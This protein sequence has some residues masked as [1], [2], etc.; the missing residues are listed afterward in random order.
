LLLGCSFHSKWAL[1]SIAKEAVNIISNKAFQVRTNI[2]ILF[3]GMSKLLDWPWTNNNKS[4]PLPIL[5]W[6]SMRV[7]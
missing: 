5:S 2:F 4:C 6:M 7:G 3:T 1:A